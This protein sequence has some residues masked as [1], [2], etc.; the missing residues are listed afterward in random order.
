MHEIWMWIFVY[1][2]FQLQLKIHKK[3]RL[4]QFM[5]TLIYYLERFFKDMFWTFPIVLNSASVDQSMGRRFSVL[6][7]LEVV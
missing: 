1:E 5:P 3:S 2:L 6:G 4:G 7:A